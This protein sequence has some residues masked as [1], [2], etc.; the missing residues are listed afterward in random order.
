MGEIDIVKTDPAYYNPPAKPVEVQLDEYSYTTI[1]GEG[2]P[3][4]EAHRAAIQALF[5]LA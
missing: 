4:Q 2:A 1:V 3:G 5:S